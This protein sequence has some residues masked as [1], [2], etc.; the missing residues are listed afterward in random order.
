MIG[1]YRT[2]D[3]HTAAQRNKEN[4]NKKATSNYLSQYLGE[5]ILTVSI[6]ELVGKVLSQ[7]EITNDFREKSVEF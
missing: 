4:S 1:L 2:E 5:L 6:V 3:L 7:E